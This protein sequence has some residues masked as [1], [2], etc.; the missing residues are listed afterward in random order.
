[1]PTQVVGLAVGLLLLAAP[2]GAQ[3]PDG[4][5]PP[6]GRKTAAAATPDSPPANSVAVL[7]FDNMSRDTADIWLA[8]GLTDEI[9]TRIGDIERVSVKSRYA[10]RPFRN[11]NV[12]PTQAGRALNVAYMVT[13]SVQRVGRRLRVTVELARAGNGDRVWGEQYDRT[14]GDVFAIQQDI[15]RGV[16]TAVAGRLLPSERATLAAR[17]TRSNAAY[18][19]LLRGDAL[20][21]QRT[22]TALRRAI[23]EYSS[24]ARADPRFAAAWAHM[25][26]AYSVLGTRSWTTDGRPIADSIQARAVATADR[27]LALDSA[28]SDVWMAQAYTRMFHDPR[29]WSG[30]EDGFRR[31]VALNARNAEAWHQLGDLLG[32]LG[33]GSESPDAYLRAL[34][35]EPGRPIT[36]LSMASSLSPA[37]AV[38]LCDSLLAV[39]PTFFEAYAYRANA[40]LAAGDT[41]GARADRDH[42]VRVA[43]AGAELGARVNA[44]R[45]TLAIGDSVDARRRALE[46]LGELPSAGPVHA[47]IG[48]MLAGALYDLGERDAAVALLERAPKGMYLWQTRNVARWGE[49][50]RVQRIF[51]ES[52]PS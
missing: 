41:L 20:L 1:V 14:D 44:M 47:R 24:A 45:I 2:L 3:C 49:D 27:A 50:A 9:I 25:S 6:C 8:Q 4:S 19:H 51:A 13:G 52:R 35:A 40:K 43:P 31:A 22:P 32:A 7:Y 23:G 29:G 18:E 5:Q 28:S 12:D 38:A 37:E 16:A 11:A 17:S 39:D 26:V 33:R 34:A 30:A 15:A 10:V 48:A 36:V 42:L 46:L 21:A